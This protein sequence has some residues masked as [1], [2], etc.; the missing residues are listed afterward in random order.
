MSN[1]F[2][3][4]IDPEIAERVRDAAAHTGRLLCEIAERGLVGELARMEARRRV[5][6]ACAQ[7][8]TAWSWPRGTEAA[9]DVTRPSP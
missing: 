2:F 6:A 9:D 4:R 3:V 1:R 7:I 8:P 5:P